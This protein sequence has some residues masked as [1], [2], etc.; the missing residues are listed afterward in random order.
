VSVTLTASH[1]AFVHLGCLRESSVT[2]FAGPAAS[3]IRRAM[4]L[5][6][7]LI[8]WT[9]AVA[10]A[11]GISSV[12]SG[13]VHTTSTTTTS[14][15]SGGAGTDTGS[16]G[17]GATPSEQPFDATTVKPTDSV[18]L[19]RTSNFARALA[20]V[21]GQIGPHAQIQ[22]LALY[23]GYLSI[24]AVSGGKEV[25][26]YIDAQGVNRTITL[27]AGAGGSPVFP[28]S[29]VSSDVPATLARRIATAGHVPESRLRYM[30]VVVDPT[31][32]QIRWLVYPSQ[33]DRVEYFAA[34]GATAPLFEYIANSSK[35][36]QPLHG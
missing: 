36:L 27:G 25:N 9:G 34:S 26:A 8:V 19:F 24:T 5:L 23:P 16:S 1:A 29:R 18:S 12:V 32:S 14:A 33:G 30:A 11:V 15:E 35:G 6:I 28:F 17:A 4:R 13:A 10:A 2:L 31:N 22:V 20:S 21:R 7:A 3:S